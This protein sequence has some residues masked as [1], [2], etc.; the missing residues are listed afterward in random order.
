MMRRRVRFACLSLAFLAKPVLSDGLPECAVSAL[1]SD[2]LE[3]TECSIQSGV[4]L[5]RF[6]GPVSSS[7]YGTDFDQRSVAVAQGS[8]AIAIRAI[9]G[10]VSGKRGITLHRN[11]LGQPPAED[12]ISRRDIVR[13]PS[14]HFQWSVITERIQYGAQG[15][16]LGF[17]LDCATALRS[18]SRQTTAV[19]EC[20]PL[21]ERR[22]FLQTLDAIR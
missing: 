6:I 7:A 9:A 3:R 5:S 16:G 14:K 12:R 1:P 18:N 11:G 8:D 4:T 19:A 10:I 20:F 22:R 13:Q 17:V 15:G 21:E 2:V